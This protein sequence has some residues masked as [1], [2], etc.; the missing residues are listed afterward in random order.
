[1]RGRHRQRVGYLDSPTN[2]TTDYTRKADC[3]TPEANRSSMPPGRYTTP[4]SL[5][6]RATVTTGMTVVEKY[7]SSIASELTYVA[8]MLPPKP[9]RAIRLRTAYGL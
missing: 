2:E 5:S 4:G 3:A 7:S 6:V 9:T 8:A 1:M